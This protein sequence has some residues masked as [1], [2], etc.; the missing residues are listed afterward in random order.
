[1]F[2]YVSKQHVTVGNPVSSVECDQRPKQSKINI[3][4]ITKGDH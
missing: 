1:M 4:R 3:L 2:I